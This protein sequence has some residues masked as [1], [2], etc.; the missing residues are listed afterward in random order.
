[1][2]TLPLSLAR[3]RFHCRGSALIMVFWLIAMLS[4]IIYSMHT[5]VSH[6]LE[7]TISQKKC[8]PRPSVGRNGHQLGH[9]P[10]REE[11]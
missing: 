5:I 8:V 6:D 2:T 10:E 1:M 11:I 9:E 4:M 7:L 3:R